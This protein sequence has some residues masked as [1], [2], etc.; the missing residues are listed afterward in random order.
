MAGLTALHILKPVDIKV[1]MNPFCKSFLDRNPEMRFETYLDGKYSSSTAVNL[2]ND[3]QVTF[4]QPWRY[5]YGNNVQLFGPNG[6]GMGVFFEDALRNGSSFSIV[7]VRKPIPPVD[8]PEPAT[9][10]AVG[11]GLAGLGLARRKKKGD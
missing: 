9:L 2:T 6:G 5:S 3:A 4:A 11:L 8:V 7:A 1:K 10:A